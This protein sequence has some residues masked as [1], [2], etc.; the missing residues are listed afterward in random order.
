MGTMRTM[1]VGLILQQKQIKTVLVTKET[2]TGTNDEGPRWFFV[3]KEARRTIVCRAE[4]VYVFVKKCPLQLFCGW[5]GM[6]L[7]EKVHR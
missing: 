3:A 4:V 6:Q 2:A 1:V 5:F 7:L